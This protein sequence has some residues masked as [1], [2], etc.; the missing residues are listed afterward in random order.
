MKNI[1]NII[2]SWWK[3]LWARQTKAEPAKKKITRKQRDRFHH[4]AHYYLTDLLDKMD[5][6]FRGMDAVK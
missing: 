4:G 6:A 2:K 5:R 1:I 3:R